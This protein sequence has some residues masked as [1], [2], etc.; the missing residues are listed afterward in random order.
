MGCVKQETLH[1]TWKKAQHKMFFC[2]IKFSIF[3]LQNNS[4]STIYNVQILCVEKIYTF[5]RVSVL[6][7]SSHVEIQ[8]FL[9]IYVP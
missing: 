8:S 2:N 4:F 6:F 5:D 9:L 3:T 7:F 1:D